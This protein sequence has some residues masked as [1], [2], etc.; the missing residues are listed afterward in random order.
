MLAI[1]KGQ[2]HSANYLAQA[3]LGT[4]FRKCILEGKQLPNS[5]YSGLGNPLASLNWSALEHLQAYGGRGEGNVNHHLSL[6]DSG[7]LRLLVDIFCGLGSHQ[8]ATGW[9]R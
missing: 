2:A 5:L 1:L 9:G 7:W 4:P 6:P 8:N 3:A